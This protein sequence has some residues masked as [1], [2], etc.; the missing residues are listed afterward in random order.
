ML[1]KWIL[2]FLL[3]LTK[4]TSVG[5]AQPPDIPE[6]HFKMG[7]YYLAI[8]N[9]VSRVDFEVA[10][11]FW[12]QEISRSVNFQSANA[13]LFDSISDMRTAFDNGELDFV[14]APPILLAKHF[15]RNSLAEGFVGT[16][17]DGNSYGTV[18]LVRSDKQINGIKDLTG[19]R[20]LMPEQDEL[21]DIFLDTL[22]IKSHRQHYEQVFSTVQSKE[23]QSSIVLALFFN[24][25]DAGVVFEET[26]NLM[27]E[28]NPQIK[29]TIKILATFPAKS[30][31][32]GYFSHNYPKPIRDRITET[33]TV[34]NKE[35]RPQQI[36][37]DLR[38]AS[39]IKCP[40]EELI[41]F[42]QLIREHQSLQRGIKQ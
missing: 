35:V 8:K 34:L 24:Q 7:V 33:V 10:L 41:P 12:L 1:K 32:Y 29:E 16:T 30:P 5:Y 3:L 36:L 4:S 31:N 18:L 21:A 26:Y 13:R 2:F 9:L 17:L 42:D 15:N 20:L 38:M 14:L 11:N 25:A 37:N 39:L 22:I 6:R 28:L 27:V 23:K 19:K 40:T